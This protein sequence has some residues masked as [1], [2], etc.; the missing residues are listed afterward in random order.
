LAGYSAKYKMELTFADFVK[1]Y[2]E[3]PALTQLVH[4]LAAAPHEVHNIV[5]AVAVGETRPL[6]ILAGIYG[7]HLTGTGRKCKDEKPRPATPDHPAA[8]GV[9][10]TVVDAWG[11][12]QDGWGCRVKAVGDTPVDVH[13]F[14]GFYAPFVSLDLHASPTDMQPAGAADAHKR[15]LGGHARALPRSYRVERYMGQDRIIDTT[16]GAPRP[17]G[18]Q[19]K[20]TAHKA[21]SSKR[22]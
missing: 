20:A 17:R 15:L 8:P 2:R 6:Y 16:P 7:R 18:S 21:H 9:Y 11:P 12:A 19:K 4:C 3:Y 1:L 14:S 5:K 13:S 22:K 10:W